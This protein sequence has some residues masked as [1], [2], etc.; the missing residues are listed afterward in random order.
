MDNPFARTSATQNCA[1]S[2]VESSKWNNLRAYVL[3]LLAR[4]SVY[5]NNNYGSKVSFSGYNDVC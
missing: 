1:F 4:Y 2:V 3:A 5:S